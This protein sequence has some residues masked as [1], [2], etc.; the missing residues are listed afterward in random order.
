MS[1]FRRTV[2]TEVVVATPPEV[3]WDVLVDAAA[4]HEWCSVLVHRSGSPEIGER[5]TLG[6]TPP[7]GRA[8]DFSPTVLVRDEGRR[9][10]WR[11]QT[12]PRGVFDGTHVFTLHEVADGTRLVNA[13]TFSGVLVPVLTRVL[14]DLD[15]VADGFDVLNDELRRRAESL[16]GP[17]R[18]H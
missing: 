13:E 11:G 15:D 8:Y 14:L 7:V 9:L 4:W 3:V 1:V 17:R 2:S 10:V 16:A 6:L 12:G 5:P 18:S